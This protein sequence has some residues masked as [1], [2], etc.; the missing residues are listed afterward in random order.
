MSPIPTHMRKGE[1]VIPLEAALD[2]VKRLILAGWGKDPSPDSIATAMRDAED[3]LLEHGKIDADGEY[4]VTPTP[5]EQMTQRH[6]DREHLAQ[7]VDASAKHAGGSPKGMD[8]SWANDEYGAALTYL[9]A[10]GKA[11]LLHLSIK[12]HD[13][14]PVHDWR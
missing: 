13:G 5:W 9:T 1:R 8:E 3:L 11:G 2:L 14:G 7:L 6:I 12:R 10:R 4:L